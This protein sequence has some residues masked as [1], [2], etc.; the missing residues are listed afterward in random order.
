MLTLLISLIVIYQLVSLSAWVATAL[1]VG[2][3]ALA[4]LA[5]RPASGLRAG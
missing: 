4:L 5:R 3:I 2:C 1:V